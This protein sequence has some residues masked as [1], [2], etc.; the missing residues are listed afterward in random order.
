MHDQPGGGEGVDAMT[1]GC[2]RGLGLDA[3]E[4]VGSSAG[5]GSAGFVAARLAE[6]VAGRRASM[7]RT[8]C[9]ARVPDRQALPPGFARPS[10]CP[11]L[12]QYVCD[13]A[14]LGGEPRTIRPEGTWLPRPAVCG[15]GAAVDRVW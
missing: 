6:P 9:V 13:S 15:A 7:R 11:S 8:K 14:T 12:R 4:E 10:R 3:K 5:A 1:Y 2:R